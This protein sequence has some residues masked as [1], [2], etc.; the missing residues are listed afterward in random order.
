MHQWVTPAVAGVMGAS[1]ESLG[2]K[3]SCV[4]WREEEDR[5]LPWSPLP[6]RH[7]STDFCWVLHTLRR[8]WVGLQLSKANRSRDTGCK[9][10]EGTQETETGE[11][12]PIDMIWSRLSLNLRE[13]TELHISDL[14]FLPADHPSPSQFAFCSP[15][16][17]QNSETMRIKFFPLVLA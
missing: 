4:L 14:F 12:F 6:S 2:C 1:G 3:I 15:A 7:R 16:F 9:P 11:E 13:K 17:R 8:K 10:V 5:A